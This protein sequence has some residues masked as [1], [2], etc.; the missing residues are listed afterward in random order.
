MIGH[1]VVA[2]LPDDGSTGQTGP[3]LYGRFF[4][5]VE[6]ISLYPP[7]R[8]MSKRKRTNIEHSPDIRLSAGLSSA[9]FLSRSHFARA[10]RKMVDLRLAEEQNFAVVSSWKPQKSG[11]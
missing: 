10:V 3:P 7:S 5:N 11:R 9:P 8:R 1:A 4:E 6:E 2:A